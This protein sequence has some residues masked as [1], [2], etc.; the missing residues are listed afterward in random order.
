M[1]KAL[2]EDSDLREYLK[3]L[4]YPVVFEAI[5]STKMNEVADRRLRDYLKG[6]PDATVFGTATDDAMIRAEAYRLAIA[7]HEELHRQLHECMSDAYSHGVV[8]PDYLEVLNGR[9]RTKKSDELMKHPTEKWASS[10]K[11]RQ[12]L[13]V[14]AFHIRADHYSEGSWIRGP[15]PDG[16]MMVLAKA[17]MDKCREAV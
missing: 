13:A 15:V 8:I 2:H 1:F 5:G 16:T 17:Y 7:E 12:V 6:L 11:P 3:A 4:P 9:I 10:L 14:I